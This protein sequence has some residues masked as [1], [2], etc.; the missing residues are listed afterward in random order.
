MN[1]P[2][3]ETDELD[4]VYELNRLFLHFLRDQAVR[5]RS[6]LGLPKACVPT[7][8]ATSAADIGAAR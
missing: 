6:C 1:E 3:A 5:G 4:Q 2:V 8:A 7:L